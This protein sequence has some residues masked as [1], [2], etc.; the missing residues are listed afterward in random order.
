MMKGQSSV[1]GRPWPKR[2]TVVASSAKSGT[3]LVATSSVLNSVE[4]CW[5]RSIDCAPKT[6]RTVA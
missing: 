1:E 5:S 3:S 4:V 2:A 6:S